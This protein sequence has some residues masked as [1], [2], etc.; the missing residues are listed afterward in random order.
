[1]SDSSKA[2]LFEVL[3]S[4]RDSMRESIV[5]FAVVFLTTHASGLPIPHLS[6]T[7]GKRPH[8]PTLIA[9]LR[10]GNVWVMNADGTGQRQLT[11]NGGVGAMG[12]T[13]TNPQWLSPSSVIFFGITPKDSEHDGTNATAGLYRY[14]LSRKKLSRLQ[15]V[16]SGL[17]GW[18]M[19]LL[20]HRANSSQVSYSID[21]PEGLTETYLLDLKSGRV[22]PFDECVPRRM[23]GVEF[24]S[25]SP[26][27]KKVAFIAGRI[28]AGAPLPLYVL[29]FKNG[30]GR[31][32]RDYDDGNSGQI[33][34][35]WSVEGSIWMKHQSNTVLTIDPKT[36]KVVNQLTFPE[37]FSDA[38]IV[39]SRRRDSLLV[40]SGGVLYRWN[41]SKTKAPER[42][43]DWVE[44]PIVSPAQ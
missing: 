5:F 23:R 30:Q 10:D 3:N 37:E 28:G 8:Q 18:N 21:I 44:A 29:S 32:L 7:V 27:G 43:A 4:L 38:K 16:R 20:S 35:F 22:K 31:K 11:K 25:W 19:R 9:F 41:W 24:P 17:G 1:M 26:N 40:V 12:V 34:F 6:A 39:D 36:G 15:T 33:S 13:Y 42:I 14:D 2:R